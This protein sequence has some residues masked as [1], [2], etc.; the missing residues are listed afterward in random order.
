MPPIFNSLTFWTLVAGLL[1][2]V[3]RYFY[4]AFPLDY[5][6][7]LSIVLFLLGLIGVVPQLRMRGA[8][9]S[10]IVHSLAFWQLVAGFLAFVI[11]FFAPSFPF[12]QTI[13]L[14]FILFLLG[15]FGITP[16]FRLHAQMKATLKDK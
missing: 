6:S 2:F 10:D 5:Q 16:E 14:G 15:W 13:L 7:I 11:H 9:T 12:D 8:F 3:A 4:P 1:A